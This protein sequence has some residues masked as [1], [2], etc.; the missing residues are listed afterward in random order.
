M[1]NNKSGGILNWSAPTFTSIVKTHKNFMSNF[2]AA[3]I[4]A[5]YEL[6]S[7]QLKRETM[8]YLKKLDPKHPLLAKVD[9]IDE[10]RFTVIGKY[11]YIINH[12]GNVPDDIAPTIML[13][14]EKIV[15]NEQLKTITPAKSTEVAPKVIVS[16]QDRLKEKAHDVAGEIEGWIDDFYMN[17]KTP[18]K[19]VDDFATLFKSYD[20]KS[21]HAR[22]ISDIFDSRVK[23]ITLAIEGKD[24]D[25][26][27]GYSNYTKAELK[28]YELFFKNLVKA[29]SMMQ[30][31][32]KVV[33]MPRKA[34]PVS[35]EK[36]VAKLKYK[37]DDTS[38]GIVSANPVQ[39]IGAKEVWLYNIRT[40]KISQYKALDEAGLTV[41]GL[42]IVNYSSESVEKTVRKPAEA[43]AEFKK[44][45]KVKLRTFMENIGT[46]GIH[47]NGKMNEN[48]LIIR[49]DK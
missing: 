32:A 7:A 42:S 20:L 18:T 14:L 6:T 12:G 24:K 15:N 46:I 2:H 41:K 23:E 4:Y 13:H 31:V 40:R 48:H 33:R 8:V 45:S 10:N 47:P 36:I 30:E 21:P 1:A 39:I 34:K 17:R 11:L 27:E 16:I 5:H 29:C 9:K 35:Q 38:L 28:K 44:A 22:I 26:T 43:L 49:I 19:S 37:K 25:L 3:M